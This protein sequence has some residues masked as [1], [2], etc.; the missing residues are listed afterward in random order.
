MTRTKGAGSDSFP[1]LSSPCFYDSHYWRYASSQQNGIFHFI[2][3]LPDALF[4]TLHKA[5]AQG[6]FQA[7]LAVLL[8]CLAL[9][10]S[11]PVCRKG[12]YSLLLLLLLLLPLVASTIGWL[13][14]GLVKLANVLFGW[15]VAAPSIPVVSGSIGFPLFR[16]GHTAFGMLQHEAAHKISHGIEK[17]RPV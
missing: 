6:W 4:Y 16:L 5:F 8:A 12:N 9:V 13:L 1:L 17:L 3:G 2:L 14:L 7:F 15:A 11:I 10:F